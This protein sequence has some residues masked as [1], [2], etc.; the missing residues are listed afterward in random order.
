MPCLCSSGVVGVARME[1]RS[2]GADTFLSRAKSL[3]FSAPSSA[4][5][6]ASGSRGDGVQEGLAASGG[7]L[8]VKDGRT[9]VEEEREMAKGPA[10]EAQPPTNKEAAKVRGTCSASSSPHSALSVYHVISCCRSQTPPP[11]EP[12]T[13]PSLDIFK[14]IFAES[15]A[16]ESESESGEDQKEGRGVVLDTMGAPQE[17]TA[18]APDKGI[19]FASSGHAAAQ[20]TDGSGSGHA[21]EEVGMDV[22]SRDH[23]Q[24]SKERATAVLFGPALPPLFSAG[25]EGNLY[26]TDHMAW[27]L[28][29]GGTHCTLCT[30]GTLPTAGHCMHPWCWLYPVSHLS[31]QSDTSSDDDSKPFKS[32]VLKEKHKK[33]KRKKESSQ[34]RHKHKVIAHTLVA[35]NTSTSNGTV[36]AYYMC[37]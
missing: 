30:G 9:Q 37:I 23:S 3:T 11:A 27:V 29:G 26:F 8:K 12:E 1:K 22:C 13:R 25:E 31:G 33:K 28:V 19:G 16:S 34:R 24:A 21:H 14:A 35:L 2:S 15:S 7:L 18:V 6:E 32:K 4:S 36:P 10:V 17:L 20:R 5:D